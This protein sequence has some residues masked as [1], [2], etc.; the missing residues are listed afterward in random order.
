MPKR[1]LLLAGGGLKVAFQAGV[2]QVWLSEA[3]LTFD[4]VDACSGGAFNLALLCDGRTGIEIADLWRQM[5]PRDG[6]SFSGS[7]F[8]HGRSI[9]TMDAYRDTIFPGWGLDFD[10]IRASPITATFTVHNRSTASRE[11]FSAAEMDLDKL[12]ATLSQAVWFPPVEID[13]HYYT[14]A[15]FDTDAN[16]D[17]ALEQGA[18]EIWVVWTVSRRPEWMPGALAQFFHALEVS[19]NGTLES[20][21]ERIRM[22][23]E[24]PDRHF[25]RHVHAKVL[26]AE[27]ATHY[28]A[29]FNGDR[30]HRAVEQ[31]VRAA[32]AWCDAQGIPYTP[33]DRSHFYD[34]DVA[35]RFS[36]RLR[37]R[38]RG[39]RAEADLQLL[40]P[41]AGAFMNTGH[42]RVE[43]RGTVTSSVLD[44]A[45]TVEEGHADIL[46]DVRS[47][48]VPVESGGVQE[49]DDGVDPTRK[50]MTYVLHLRTPTGRAVTFLGVKDVSTPTVRAAAREAM[51]M[52][53]R[54][55]E[56][57]VGPDDE[58]VELATGLLWMGFRDVA[59]QLVGARADGPSLRAEAAGLARYGALFAG[60]LWDVA[61]RKVLTYAPF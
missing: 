31:G 16:V 15:V 26:R 57:W 56:G 34:T 58:A 60:S 27:V 32:R 11:T 37:G 61:A 50:L 14:D 38:L 4:H 19:A 12:V 17:A 48:S 21:L 39:R 42:Q 22:N 20:D 43:V 46:L 53:C 35:L 8:L 25:G 54:V 29:L 51:T 40:V 44:G 23:N 13:G 28:L 2:L 45:A 9:V 5:R 10:R 59:A 49:A 18:D 24:V 55:L 33:I 30:L 6:V 36:D 7:G 41:D 3:G 52:S 1:S 47:P